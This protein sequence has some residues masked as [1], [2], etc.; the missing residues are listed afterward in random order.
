MKPLFAIAALALAV[1]PTLPPG[2]SASIHFGDPGRDG[3]QTTTVK[4][5]YIDSNGVKQEKSI[6]AATS[7][8]SG[9]T[10][11]TKRPLVQANL[12]AAFNLDVSKVGGQPLCSTSGSGN[13]MNITPANDSQGNFSDVKLEKVTTND[14]K[15]GEKDAILAASLPSLGQVE[16]LGDV[17]GSDGSGPSVF[18]VQ[19]NL[20]TVTVNLTAGM[21]RPVIL[22]Q[23]ASGLRAQGATTWVDTDLM[24]LFVYIPGGGGTAITALG[25]GSTDVGLTARAAVLSNN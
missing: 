23:L 6:S 19:T 17:T 11:Q 3:E 16:V 10:P 18:E 14:K 5:S 7:L 8:T 15:T 1:T 13:A 21:R 12:D 2:G 20:G 22:R 9:D 25:A 24:V 4:V